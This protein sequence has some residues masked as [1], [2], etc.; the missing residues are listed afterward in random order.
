[1]G[2]LLDLDW[3]HSLEEETTS[4][5]RKNLFPISLFPKI[6]P[7]GNIDNFITDRVVDRNWVPISHLFRLLLGNPAVGWQQG[8]HG[9]ISEQ[10]DTFQF[11]PTF[12]TLHLSK[13][14][15]RRWSSKK[16]VEPCYGRIIS[17]SVSI[18]KIDNLISKIDLEEWF[19]K[20]DLDPKTKFWEQ[21][22]KPIQ[23]GKK[24]PK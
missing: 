16:F 10:I 18:S 2:R 7:R 19:L 24:W 6:C 15:Q 17:K 12:Q 22:T 23:R 11:S 4:I 8:L 3:A 9:G 14:T 5:D 20:L 21:M 13:P 1:M